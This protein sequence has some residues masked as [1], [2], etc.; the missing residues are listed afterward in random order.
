MGGV[1]IVDEGVMALGGLDRGRV[2]PSR[3]PFL[4]TQRRT[5]CYFARVKDMDGLCA[6]TYAFHYKS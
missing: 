4:Y 5:H 3:I 6:L 2:C 1:L